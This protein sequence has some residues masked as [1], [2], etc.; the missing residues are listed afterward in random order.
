M[1]DHPLR[2]R[3]E[4]EVPPEH[5]A[6]VRLLDPELDGI[7][8]RELANA[9]APAVDCGRED[10]ISALGREVDILV[11]EFAVV[12]LVTFYS[13]VCLPGERVLLLLQTPLALFVPPQVVFHPVGGEEGAHDG[14]H[15]LD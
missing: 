2:L 10:D 6:E 15:I 4:V 11:L 7:Q 13:R 1:A 14:V 3:V 9:E 5:C 12:L 8:V